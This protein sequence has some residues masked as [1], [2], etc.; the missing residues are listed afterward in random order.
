MTRSPRRRPFKVDA[1]TEQKLIDLG[2]LL[3]TPEEV[4][5]ALDRGEAATADALAARGSK[6]AKAYNQGRAYG[7][8]ALRRAQLK[9]AETSV[10]MAI[11][12]GKTELGQSERR[13]LDLGDAIDLSEAGRRAEER[14]AA[15]IAV[16]PEADAGEAEGGVQ[17]AS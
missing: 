4:A 7:V 5:I 16:A 12:L 3:C 9:L 6:A 17:D 13:E 10:T 14:L 8:K 15:L 11:F 1:E 2:Q